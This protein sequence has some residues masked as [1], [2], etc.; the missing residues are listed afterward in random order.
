MARKTIVQVEDSL[1]GAPLAE[2]TPVSVLFFNGKMVELDLGP[3]SIAQV[4]KAL[5]KFFAKGTVTEGVSVS[6][7]RNVTGSSSGTRTDFP[8]LSDVDPADIRAWAQSKGIQ[9]SDHGRIKNE[10]LRQYVD[11]V[12]N[13]SPDAESD[14][15]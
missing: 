13:V 11:E 4:E 10:V 7:R 14:A 1:S 6:V 5:G 15:A 8:E 9:V 12:V 3:D 2:D